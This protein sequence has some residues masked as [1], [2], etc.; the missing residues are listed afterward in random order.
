MADDTYQRRELGGLAARLERSR[1]YGQWLVLAGVRRTNLRWFED[2]DGVKPFGNPP[3]PGIPPTTWGWVFANSDR[4]HETADQASV[5][6]RLSSPAGAQR[7]WTAGAYYFS[8]HVDRQEDFLVKFSLLPPADGDISF[9]QDARNRSA[10]LYGEIEWPL[11]AG[12]SLRTG[13]RLTHDE[14]QIVQ[15]ARNNDAADPTPGLPLFPGQPYRVPAADRFSSLT[16]RLVLGYQAGAAQQAER[17]CLL[18]ADDAIF[19][20]IP[21]SRETRIPAYALL[22]AQLAWRHPGGHWEVSAWGRN[23]RDRVY[24]VHMIPFL[25]NGYALLGAPRTLGVS[26]AWHSL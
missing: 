14:K 13:A 20:D 6:V 1:D 23:L 8:E 11:A 24:A 9:L 5:E 10:A 18:C 12:L 26:A 22:D 16:G 3:L 21:N 15:E 17:A 2:L 7:A 25:G 19:T 4:A